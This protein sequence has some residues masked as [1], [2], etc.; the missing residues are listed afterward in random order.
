MNL[1]SFLLQLPE[2]A[3]QGNEDVL[4]RDLFG[5]LGVHLQPLPISG[6]KWEALMKSHIYI[7]KRYMYF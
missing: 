7:F 6:S 2:A 1:K 3:D 5:S 4:P